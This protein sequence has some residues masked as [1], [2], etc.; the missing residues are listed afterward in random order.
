MLKKTNK[1]DTQQKRKRRNSAEINGTQT[2]LLYFL[3]MRMKQS[4]WL[5]KAFTAGR[6]FATGSL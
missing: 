5:N 3:S 2:N 6:I 4:D 1:Y